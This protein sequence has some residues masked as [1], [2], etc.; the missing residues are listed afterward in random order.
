MPEPYEG[1]DEIHAYIGNRTGV[2]LAN[3]SGFVQLH[4]LKEGRHGISMVWQYDVVMAIGW[5][6]MAGIVVDIPWYMF[7][8]SPRLFSQL[9]APDV[10]HR[11]VPPLQAT[12]YHQLAARCRKCAGDK[13]RCVPAEGLQCNHCNYMECVPSR[14]ETIA[15]IDACY[16]LAQS[17]FFALSPPYQHLLMC[18]KTAASYNGG[19]KMS[20]T[21]RTQL[22]ALVRDSFVGGD[23]N[24]AIEGVDAYQKV[25][26]RSG[27]MS[28]LDSMGI[29]E[30]GFPAPPYLNPR[31]MASSCTPHLGVADYR[32]ALTIVDNALEEPGIV[33]WKEECVWKGG[34]FMSARIFSVASIPDV[35][36]IFIVIG[37]KW[38]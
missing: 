5:N 21:Q 8:W 14:K 16:G 23:T 20:H 38:N 31:K 27:K 15:R 25:V 9:D 3:F 18:T 32:V 1:I 33:H 19:P 7:P 13:V 36:T 37:F 29:G 28:V 11:P 34:H 22:G 24:I 26:F 12:I 2:E 35:D 6:R 10:L 17:V 30:L 4:G